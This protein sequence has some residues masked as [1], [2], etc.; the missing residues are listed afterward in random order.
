[1]NFKIFK[2]ILVLKFDLLERC[3]YFLQFKIIR[4][5]DERGKNH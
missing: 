3:L 4:G 1:M 2:R 5:D